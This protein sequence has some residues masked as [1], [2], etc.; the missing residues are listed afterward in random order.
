MPC[1]IYSSFATELFEAET[2]VFYFDV[3]DTYIV[4]IEEYSSISNRVYSIRNING[5]GLLVHALQ[6]TVPEFTKEITKNGDKIR[7]PDEEAIQ[8][9]S[10]KIQ[11]IREKFNSWLDNQPIGIREELVRLYNERFN[12]YVRPSYN[13][14]AQTFPALSFEQLKYKELYPSQKDAVW[15]IKQNSGGVC[16]HDVG[17]GKTMI[18]CIAAYEMKRLGLAQ[19]PLI[20]GLKANIHQIAADFRK[21]Y[22]NAKILYPGKE[23]FKPKMRQEIFSKIKNNNWDCILLTHDQFAK[24]PQSEETQIAIFEEELAD[25]ERSLL[26]LQASGVQWSNRKMKKALEKRQENLE[27]V[28]HSLKNA[29]NR[30]KDNSIDFHTMGIDHI[31]VDEYH[32]FKNLMFQT[33]HSRVAGIG[34]SRG[35]QRALNLLIAIRD[36]QRRSGKDFGATFLSGTIIV[37]A[38]TE[39]YVLFK[40]L[41]PQEL[42][43]QQISCFDAWA[44]IFTKKTERLRAK[45]YRSIKRKERFRTYIK[46]PE[47]AA[48]LRE[49]TDYRT[50]E[51]INLDIPEKNVRFLT[52]EPTLAQE[53]MINRLVSFAH[54]GKWEDLGLN[55]P[56]PENLDAAKML[57][58]T[59]I[60]RKWLSICEC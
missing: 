45:C 15:M 11:E 43:R 7:I 9:A 55:Y 8:A 53:E 2:K 39:L 50:A 56:A 33:R 34:N 26:V 3:N 58:A 47:L 60:A 35:S 22:P 10:V 4:S 37:N 44:A 41:R 32:F 23:D 36:I 1:D 28:L 54:T 40:Y 49:I 51:M 46:V 19:K 48:F 27:T 25:V 57:I 31:L 42:K 18:M 12:C 17:A 59:D 5:E 13:G 16:W 14:S 24:I 20:I 30:K 38:L 29:I 6:D 52:N 21:A